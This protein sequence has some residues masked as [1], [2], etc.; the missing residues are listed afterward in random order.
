MHDLKKFLKNIFLRLPYGIKLWQFTRALFLL[1]EESFRKL[2]L[3][4]SKKDDS[5][6]LNCGNVIKSADRVKNL[7]ERLESLKNM[8]EEDL[9]AFYKKKLRAESEEGSK[10]AGVGLIEIARKSSEFEFDFIDLNDGTSFF[11]LKSILK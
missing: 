8:S 10:G 3:A 11:L 9:K 4:I 5:Y 1:R 2:F 6:I 7:R